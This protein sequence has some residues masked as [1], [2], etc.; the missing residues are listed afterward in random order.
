MLIRVAGDYASTTGR[1]R[2]HQQQSAGPGERQLHRSR[3]REE[4]PVRRAR[5]LRGR[6]VTLLELR[7]ELRL[8]HIQSGGQRTA[9]DE[10][11][12]DRE[13]RRERDMLPNEVGDE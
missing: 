10:S 9:G 2:A 7:A 1:V 3:L 6:R 12:E 8:E 4:C 5:V 11:L 13:R